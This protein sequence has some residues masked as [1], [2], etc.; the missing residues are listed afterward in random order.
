M[1]KGQLIGCFGLTEPDYG[2]NPGGMITTAKKDGSHYVLNGT[3]MW[4]TN[5]GVSDLAIVWA[6]VPDN[7][8]KIHGF[9]VDRDLKGFT[10]RD[11]HKKFS[12][13][14]SVTSELFFEDV[15]VPASQILNVTGLKGP[16]ACLGNARYGISWGALGAAMA[17]YYE[18]LT[19]AK[20]RIQFDKPI[21]SYQ[22]VQAKLA[23]MYTE[24]TKGQLLALDLSLLKEKGKAFWGSR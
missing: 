23:E 9:I 11:I 12:L 21:A 6:K 1:A 13:R 17:C 20:T 8:N 3:K 10:T 2:S 19:Y 7:D 5:G 14:A 16:F 18:A 4:I 22:L 15:S 24:I